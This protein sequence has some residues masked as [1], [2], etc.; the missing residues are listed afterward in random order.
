MSPGIDDLSPNELAA[1]FHVC[2]DV[3]P[4]YTFINHE[5]RQ[6]G[7]Q[8]ELSGTHENASGHAEPGCPECHKVYQAMVR[9]AESVLAEKNEDY[10][11]EIQP[12]DQGIRYSPRHGNRPEI[13]LAIRIFHRKDLEHPVDQ[14][15]TSYVNNI[16]QRL[17]SLGAGP[18]NWSVS[19]SAE[20]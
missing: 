8:L 6:T 14:A 15:A 17:E 7:F 5:K 18:N 2:S 12:Y 20:R 3:W 19:K 16:Q 1:H 13:T 9:I 11:Y 4:D 10:T